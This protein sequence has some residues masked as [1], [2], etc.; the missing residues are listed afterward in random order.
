MKH[1]SYRYDKFIM[2]IHQAIISFESEEKTLNREEHRRL[3]LIGEFIKTVALANTVNYDNCM[4]LMRMNFKRK[5][6]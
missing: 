5:D 4:M 3:L 2:S 1:N 6:D